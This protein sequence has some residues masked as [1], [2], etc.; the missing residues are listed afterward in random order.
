MKIFTPKDAKEHKL[1][2]IP[3]FVY[4]AFNNLLAKNYDAYGTII[5]QGEV[6]KEILTVCPLDS[7][8][9]Q[10]ILENKWLDVED[11]YRK[12]GWEV[13]YEKQGLGE[14]YPARFIFKPKE[15]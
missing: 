8:T 3:D 15:K 10:I 6:I 9:S 4:Q 5:L 14:S 13:E 7:M 1:A 11:E 12:N 2:S